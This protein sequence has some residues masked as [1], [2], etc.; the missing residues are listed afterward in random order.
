M[1]LTYLVLILSL[2][3]FDV[4]WCF[5]RKH[6][7]NTTVAVVQGNVIEG[8]IHETFDYEDLE[9]DLKLGADYNKMSFYYYD[10]LGQVIYKGKINGPDDMTLAKCHPGQKF[11][12][13]V[14]GWT[15]HCEKEVMKLLAMK[16]KRYRGGC[17]TCFDYGPYASD[18]N[19]FRLVR[20]FRM[21]RDALVD[22][23]NIMASQGLRFQD[24]HGWG[25]SY[26]ARLILRALERVNG[27]YESVD[28]CDMAGPGFDNR[29]RNKCDYRNAADNVQCIYTS[30]NRGTRCTTGCHQNWRMGQ[31]GVYQEAAGNIR[32]KSHA[33]CPLF[34]IAAF[35][36][37]FYAI[38]N[39]E[40]AASAIA[41]FPQGYQMGYMEKDKSVR[42]ELFAYTSK[43]P[44]YNVLS[45]Y[46]IQYQT[47]KLTPVPE[48][49]TIFELTE[50]EQWYGVTTT[51]QTPET[52]TNFNDNYFDDD[53]QEQKTVENII[54]S[55]QTTT[56]SVIAQQF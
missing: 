18:P 39:K 10:D 48:N 37:P 3:W 15:Q 54:D 21:L 52:S 28:I 22:K 53:D 50:E 47:T 36:H 13:L 4:G 30:N 29:L 9:N 35:E 1:K 34:Y 55:R 33:M 41:A 11:T 27:R 32:T 24:S 44:P 5:K 38:P 16:Y 46:I 42:G 56:I 43:N 7:E 45:P 49:D 2:T 31:C 14:H 40:C 6:K 19:Y 26:G 12:V 20:H 23:L 25:F 51:E 8:E 17:V